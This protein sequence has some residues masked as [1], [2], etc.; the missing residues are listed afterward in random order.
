MWALALARCG[1]PAPPL[2]VLLITLDTTR[3]DH[4]SAYGY[5]RDTSPRLAELAAEGVR[6]DAAYAPTA[7]TAPSHASLFTAAMPPLHGVLKNGIPLSA[8]LPTLA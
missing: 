2:N 8:E 3:T 4:L 7:T 5:A 6:F 1:A